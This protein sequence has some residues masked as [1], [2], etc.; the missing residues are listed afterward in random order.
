MKKKKRVFADVTKLR[1]STWDY[2]G[3]SGWV[4]K[5]NYMC[6][7]GREAEG[8]KTQKGDGSGVAEPEMGA[9]SSKPSSSPEPG[10]CESGFSPPASGERVAL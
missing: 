4:L 6:L 5:C 1:L 2:P 7:Y 10:G 3:L 9:S 8:E